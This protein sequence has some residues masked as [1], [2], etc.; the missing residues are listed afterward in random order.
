M[1]KDN[2]QRVELD[3]AELNVDF[4]VLSQMAM[5]VD[6]EFLPY[7]KGMDMSNVLSLS[8]TPFPPSTQYVYFINNHEIDEKL[9]V[10]L[11]LGVIQ[12]MKNG[13]KYLYHAVSNSNDN[14][15][16]EM[17]RLGIYY[18]IKFPNYNDKKLDQLLNRTSGGEEHIRL[19]MLSHDEKIIND[20]KNVFY[21][22]KGFENNV[23][24]F[25]KRDVWF[26]RTS[27]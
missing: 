26:C 9:A 3:G 11:G 4:I 17:L 18:Q 15:A 20:L 25:K 23:V 27:W 24:K 1:T 2:F 13:E 21:S 12:N 14:M 6:Y 19:L 8:K 7:E 16:D 5:T 10:S 22:Q